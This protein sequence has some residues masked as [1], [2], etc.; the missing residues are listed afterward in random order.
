[1]L[2]WVCNCLS[3]AFEGWD[4]TVVSMTPISKEWWKVIVKENWKSSI[5]TARNR[6]NEIGIYK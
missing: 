6:L 3:L 4:E 5:E 2:I 1:M